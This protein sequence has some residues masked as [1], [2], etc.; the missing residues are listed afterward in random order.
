MQTARRWNGCNSIPAGVYIQGFRGFMGI[1]LS[2]LLNKIYE[3]YWWIK[4]AHKENNG[5]FQVS[6]LND[7][8][9]KWTVDEEEELR[10]KKNE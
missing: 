9:A 8:K 7:I 3:N 5:I 4:L 1:L 10:R 6:C 2:R